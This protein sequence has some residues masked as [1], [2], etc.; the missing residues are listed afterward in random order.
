ML[1]FLAEGG[2]ADTGGLAASD[3]CQNILHILIRDAL[4]YSEGDDAFP[5]REE[6]QPS[7]NGG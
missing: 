1:H 7:I 2:E 4:I 5:R 3:G 6:F